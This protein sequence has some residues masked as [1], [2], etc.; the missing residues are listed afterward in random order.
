MHHNCRPIR[1]WFVNWSIVSSLRESKKVAS[2][3]F[4][5]KA[6]TLYYRIKAV[7]QIILAI[8]LSV[9]IVVKNTLTDGVRY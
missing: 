2:P 7:N 1:F 5:T 4:Q 8:Y 6:S 9:E 3:P